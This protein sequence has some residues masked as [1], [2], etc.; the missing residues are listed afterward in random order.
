MKN[1]KERKNI[2]FMDERQ[3]QIAQKA[4]ANGCSKGKC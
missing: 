3:S 4:S 2:I 1:N